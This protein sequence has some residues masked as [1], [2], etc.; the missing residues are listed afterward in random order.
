MHAIQCLMVKRKVNSLERR[1]NSPEKEKQDGG[2]QS[3]RGIF[4]FFIIRQSGC[5]FVSIMKLR[6]RRELC[7]CVTRINEKGWKMR[8]L[9]GRTIFLKR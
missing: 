2:D 9:E 4:L 5:R 1:A 3:F 8:P 6:G 7:E